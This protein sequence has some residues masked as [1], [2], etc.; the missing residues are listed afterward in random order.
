M[1]DNQDRLKT[2]LKNSD[3]EHRPLSAKNKKE[4]DGPVI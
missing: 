2:G 1:T 4:E 3:E